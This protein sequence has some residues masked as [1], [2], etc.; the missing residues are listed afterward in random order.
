M[1]PVIQQVRWLPFSIKNKVQNKLKE[2]S[3]EI[4]QSEVCQ[5]CLYKLIFMGYVFSD[6][7]V[8][9]LSKALMEACRPESVT[10]DYCRVCIGCKWR[11]DQY[12]GGGGKMGMNLYV[13][14][15]WGR[16]DLRGNPGDTCIGLWD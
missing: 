4:S 6:K 11:T 7:G 9:N 16:G 15:Q 13:A 3:E 1:R 14:D 10:E 2:L 5:F 12:L 8:S